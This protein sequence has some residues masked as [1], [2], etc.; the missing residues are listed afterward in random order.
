MSFRYGPVELYLVGFDGDRPEPGVV[1]AL[2]SLVGSGLIRLL[3][4]VILSREEDGSVEVIEIEDDDDGFGFGD[5][6]LA[7]TGIAGDED[8][9]ELAELLEPGTSA[10]LVAFELVYARQLAG[11]LADSGAVVLSAERIP[12]PVVNAIMDADDDVDAD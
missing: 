1:D 10:A 2:Q 12:A 5:I 9:E 8:I 3:D 7:E 4:L 11:A 6:E